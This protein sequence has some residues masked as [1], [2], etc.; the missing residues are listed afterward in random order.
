MSNTNTDNEKRIDTLE[1]EVKE[2]KEKVAEL[3]RLVDRLR[4]PNRPN[5]EQVVELRQA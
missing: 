2:L 3:S 1:Q 4:Y 5:G